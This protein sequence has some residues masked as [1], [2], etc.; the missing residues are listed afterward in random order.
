M[1]YADYLAHQLVALERTNRGWMTWNLL[2]ALVPAV[3][4]LGLF[5][6]PHRR[7]AGWW[8][9]V[10]AFALFLPNAP[11]VVTD[12]VHLRADVARAD[13][14]GVVLAGVLPMYGAFVALGF[15]AYLACTELVGREVRSVRPA[16]PQWAVELVLHAVSALGIVLGRIAR[17]NSWDTLT[18]PTGTAER[19]FTTLT[20]RG[21]P[22]AFVAVLVAVA[23]THLVVRTLAVAAGRAATAAWR[24]WPLARSA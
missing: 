3:L 6:R 21:A 7:R 22:V 9:G 5:A 18:A 14:D 19:V 17:L 23:A 8:A 12:L 1:H 15:L 4:A 24:R 16:T 20:W 10:V 2:L 11:Y 13:S